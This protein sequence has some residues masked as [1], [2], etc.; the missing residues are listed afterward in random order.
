M[1]SRVILIGHCL[2]KQRSKFLPF[3][4]DVGGGN[5]SKPMG[6]GSPGAHRTAVGVKLDMNVLPGL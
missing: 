1:S 6:P 4:S 2:A 3:L 5:I